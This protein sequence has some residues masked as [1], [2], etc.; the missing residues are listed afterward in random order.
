MRAV[1][2]VPAFSPAVVEE[3]TPLF[4]LVPFVRAFR[5]TNVEQ[6]LNFVIEALFPD[7]SGTVLIL[8][9]PLLLGTKD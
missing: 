3:R 4:V 2:V 6:H 7:L 9:Q 5:R 8:L 1:E